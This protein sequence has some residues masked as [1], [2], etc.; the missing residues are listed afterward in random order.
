MR[1]GHGFAE[2]ADTASPS[3]HPRGFIEPRSPDWV[4]GL[5]LSVFIASRSMMCGHGDF[6]CKNRYLWVTMYG[7]LYGSKSK[8]L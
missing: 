5:V 3:P 1:S 6:L 7:L 4:T 8:L 2:S